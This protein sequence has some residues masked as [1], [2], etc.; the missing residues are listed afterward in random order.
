MSQHHPYPPVE[1]PKP[2]RVPGAIAITALC[3]AILAIVVGFLLQVG[4]QQLLIRALDAPLNSRDRAGEAALAALAGL[5]QSAL[6]IGALLFAGIAV[7]CWLF[8]AR[9]NL[10]A[11]GREPLTW[12]RG[13][14]IGGWFIPI[15]NLFIPLSVVGEID[16]KSATAADGTRTH[17][18]ILFGLWATTWTLYLIVDRIGAAIVIVMRGTT[19]AELSARMPLTIG[20]GIVSTLLGISAA[21]SMIALIRRI[22][23]NQDHTLTAA[24]HAYYQQHYPSYPAL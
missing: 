12:G 1:A 5:A 8:R 23:A 21:A 19:A 15:A 16:T 11:F 13:W 6:V 14:T 24:A 3:L 20:V 2:L 22:G 7:I 17:G 9:T 10:T 18:R 4:S